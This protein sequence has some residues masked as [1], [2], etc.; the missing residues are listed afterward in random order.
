MAT[1]LEICYLDYNSTLYA[2]LSRDDGI[3]L[4]L[5]TDKNIAKKDNHELNLF[6]NIL[7]FSQWFLKFIT[8]F[9][10]GVFTL[11]AIYM[12]PSE[13]FFHLKNS[14]YYFF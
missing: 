8:Y 7:L 5:S 4:I 10:S 12:C 14:L 11:S 13:I 1:L 9:F 6:M 3:T 2:F